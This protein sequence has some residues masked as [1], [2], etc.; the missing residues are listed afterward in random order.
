MRKYPIDPK[1]YLG[2]CGLSKI[3]ETKVLKTK[4]S[5]MKVES[6]AESSLGPFCNTFDL[7][8][9]IICLE[10]QLLVFFLSGALDKFYCNNYGDFRQD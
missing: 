3:D 7:H 10:K 5:L 1:A 9:V 2:S 8:Y 6:I 4:G